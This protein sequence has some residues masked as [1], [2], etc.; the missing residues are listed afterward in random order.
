M[1]P[2]MKQHVA[3]CLFYLAALVSVPSLSQ[4]EIPQS[5][6]MTKFDDITVHHSIF[7]STSALPKIAN[8]LGLVRGKDYVWINIAVTPNNNTNTAVALGKPAR[9]TGT[10]KN[11]MQQVKKLEF[12]EI[13]ESTATYYIAPLRVTEEE[14]FHFAFQVTPQFSDDATANENAKTYDIKLTKKLYVNE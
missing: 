7:S 13:R 6:Y 10:A 5:E 3:F 11:L 4:S 8:Q 9:V 1:T 2:F 14:I 12:K